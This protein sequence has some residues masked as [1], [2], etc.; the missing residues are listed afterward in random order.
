[1][2]QSHKDLI[3]EQVYLLK[4]ERIVYHMEHSAY[5]YSDM[6][7]PQG[8]HVFTKWPSSPNSQSFYLTDEEVDQSIRDGKLVAI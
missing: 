1:V 6:L 2:L 5:Q 3:D 7:R 4:N 8:R